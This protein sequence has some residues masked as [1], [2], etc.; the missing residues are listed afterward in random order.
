MLR[1][2]KVEAMAEMTFTNGN[3]F[4]VY[5]LW[6][7]CSWMALEMTEVSNWVNFG[8]KPGRLTSPEKSKQHA[9]PMIRR[10][11]QKKGMEFSVRKIWDQP[12]CSLGRVWT[13]SHHWGSPPYTLWPDI[14]FTFPASPGVTKLLK[15]LHHSRPLG[16]IISL[17]GYCV[18]F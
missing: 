13:V 11:V 7:A 3:Y 2:S 14:I 18:T 16:Q 5:L 4:W 6:C 17:P 12:T 8:R 1:N 10:L 15:N 9:D